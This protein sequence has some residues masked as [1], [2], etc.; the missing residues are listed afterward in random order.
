[1]HFPEPLG[2]WPPGTPV[3]NRAAVCC[4]T[5]AERSSP[6]SRNAHPRRRRLWRAGAR[7]PWPGRERRGDALGRERVALG[8]RRCRLAEPAPGGRL[9]AHR[10]FRAVIRRLR[11]ARGGGARPAPEGPGT[12]FYARRSGRR[13][14]ARECTV[15]PAHAAAGTL[16]TASLPRAR[17]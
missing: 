14:T 8:E 11:A 4:G 17:R 7:S 13:N 6:P 3:R 10:R 16:G 2:H 9:R 1:M 12:R 5:Q 15:G